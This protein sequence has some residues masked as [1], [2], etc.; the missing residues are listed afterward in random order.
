MTSPIRVFIADADE[1]FCQAAR[2]MLQCPD[3]TMIGQAQHMGEMMAQ[4]QTLQPDVLLMD[5]GLLRAGDL[6]CVAQISQLCPTCRLVLLTLQEQDH[7]LVEA[8]RAG[9]QGYLIK[10]TSQPH[11]IVEAV[12]TVHRGG[13][14]LSPSM[15]GWILDEMAHR[16]RTG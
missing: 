11:E 4:I 12:R 16:Y 14:I 15:L 9:A 13:S 7:L 3:I 5:V 6:H 10:G 2:S 8:L 1:L